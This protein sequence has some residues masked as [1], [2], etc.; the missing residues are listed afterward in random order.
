MFS[1]VHCGEHE[2]KRCEN[3]WRRKAE[4]WWRHR[5]CSSSGSL[6]GADDGTCENDRDK[7]PEHCT[8]KFCL[9]FSWKWKRM[10]REGWRPAGSCLSRWCSSMRWGTKTR[11]PSPGTSLSTKQFRSQTRWFEQSSGSSHPEC[12]QRPST[13]EC[14]SLCWWCLFTRSL[15]RKRS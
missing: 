6:L 13:T 15:K 10:V 4:H 2:I 14:S 7:N 3:R 1:W 9:T 8:I 12:Q 5:G 11:S